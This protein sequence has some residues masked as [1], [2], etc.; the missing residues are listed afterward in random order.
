VDKDI[1]TALIAAVASIIVAL[2]PTV[3]ERTHT[4]KS[5]D[6]RTPRPLLA[7]VSTLALLLAVTSL[8]LAVKRP[9]PTPT[10]TVTSEMKWDLTQK[11]PKAL[12]VK[13][14]EGV[15]FL[16]GLGGAFAGSVENVRVEVI[17]GE[18]M[19]T[20]TSAQ[21]CLQVS[22]RCFKYSVSNV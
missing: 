1:A 2:V 4:G 9:E 19:L 14:D 6:G 7:F 17:D 8:V 18:Y 3:R 22:A 20:G 11:Q 13:A 10:F 5:G 12:G 21:C 16:T 15:C